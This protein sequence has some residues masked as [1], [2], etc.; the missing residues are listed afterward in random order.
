MSMPKIV[1]RVADRAGRGRQGLG[2]V[3]ARIFVMSVLAIIIAFAV[4]FIVL[5][6]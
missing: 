6:H 4:L 1:G 2:A 3:A 5:G